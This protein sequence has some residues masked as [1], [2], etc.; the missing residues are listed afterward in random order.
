[1]SRIEAY[2]QTILDL[3]NLLTLSYYW[4]N[5]NNIV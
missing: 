3:I 1:M 5:G 4:E 2:Y